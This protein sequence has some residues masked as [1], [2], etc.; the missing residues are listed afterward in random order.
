M[1]WQHKIAYLLDQS[2][3]I[4]FMDGTGTSGILC[5][6]DG[7]SLYVMEYLYHSQFALKHYSYTMILDIHPFPSCNNR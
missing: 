7:S 4:S 3:G 1:P 5:D 6:A 2:V